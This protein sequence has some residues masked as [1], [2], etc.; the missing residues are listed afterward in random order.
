MPV[1]IIPDVLKQQQQHVCNMRNG[2]AMHA[3]Y[4]IF[5]HSHAPAFALVV[6]DY[7]L[8]I[9]RIRT[10]F[11]Y[12]CYIDWYILYGCRSNYYISWKWKHELLQRYK[13]PIQSFAKAFLHLSVRKY[14]SIAMRLI[15]TI[16]AMCFAW[17]RIAPEC[18][19][20]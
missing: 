14:M 7:Q 9:V 12:S 3:A 8:F 10:S 11:K 16:G 18:V 17:M 13:L 2:S 6:Y 19:Y 15:A 1:I 20:F 4:L 5:F